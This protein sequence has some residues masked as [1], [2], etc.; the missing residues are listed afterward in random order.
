MPARKKSSI[1]QNSK[2][3]VS[4]KTPAIKHLGVI[5]GGGQLPARL[6]EACDKQNIEVFVIGFDGHTSP[7]VLKGR[8]H[9]LTR[10]GA[11]SQIINTLKA[12]EIKNLVMVGALKRPTLSELR[13]DTRTAK[14]F[15][16]VGLKALGDDGLLKAVK[17][18]LENEGF[19]IHGAH[20]FAKELL[21][22]EG[23]LGKANPNR[24]D[25]ADIKR[26]VEIL[27]HTS[28][29]DIGQAVI[30]QQGIVLGIEAI[31]GTDALIERCAS[32]Q[33]KGKGG[34][35]VKL[36]KEG[37]DENLDLPTIGPHTIKMAKE[38]GLS[39]IA[40]HA[41]KSL[42]LESQTVAT[43]ADQAKM[44]VIGINPKDY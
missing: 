37:Q 41:G 5:A 29:L 3:E 19:K 9:M 11:A 14:F 6:L 38:A 44:F 1:K 23:T 24:A 31:E 34:V 25:I 32:Y 21:A 42:L 39:G 28:T 8:T 7:E 33:R 30:I 26:G 35:L 10:V 17:S 36:C 2:K 20:Q 4:Q 16:R 12:H 18:E 40:I 15:A 22:G 27:T 13:P 43:K